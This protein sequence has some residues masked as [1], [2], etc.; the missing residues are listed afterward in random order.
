MYNIVVPPLNITGH[1]HIG[2][3]LNLVLQGIYLHFFRLQNSWANCQ[4]GL[5]H[6]G[7]ATKY[8]LLKKY[9]RINTQGF[10]NW[11]KRIAKCLFLQIK[12]ILNYKICKRLRFS[13]DSPFNVAVKYA[14]VKLFHMK[15][16]KLKTKM[17]WWDRRLQ[18]TISDIDL[19]EVKKWKM[20]LY[21]KYIIMGICL[22][23][24]KK[25]VLNNYISFTKYETM[26]PSCKVI[27]TINDLS[28]MA[29]KNARLIDASTVINAKLLISS[30]DHNNVLAE[31]YIT[32]SL[33]F[34]IASNKHYVIFKDLYLK[35]KICNYDSFKWVSFY[36]N[37]R[38]NCHVSR[39]ISKQWFV[40]LNWLKTKVRTSMLLGNYKSKI[41]A[42]IKLWC[43]SRFIAWG[44]KIPV[45]RFYEVSIV[46]DSMFKASY[47]YMILTAIT[48]KLDRKLTIEFYQESLVFD[49]WFSSALW[50]LSCL[51]WPHK[52]RQLRLHYKS[53]IIITGHDIVFFWV[54]K[55]ILISAA[56]M[57]WQLPFIKIL[58]HPIICDHSGKKMSK[59]KGN[60]ISP[61]ALINTFGINAL[62]L[63]LAG[64]NFNNNNLKIC[65]N[66]INFCK[67]IISKLWNL[68]QITFVN[69]FCSNS[70][71]C[72]WAISHIY[73][74]VKKIKFL[75]NISKL[76]KYQNELL[77]L[78]K[79]DINNI[80][81]NHKCPNH[82]LTLNSIFSIFPIS[83]D[84]IYQFNIFTYTKINFLT[85]S[86]IIQMLYKYNDISTIDIAITNSKRLFEQVSA[87]VREVSIINVIFKSKL[88]ITCNMNLLLWNN[89]LI[90]LHKSQY[91]HY[92]FLKLPSDQQKCTNK[93]LT[94]CHQTPP[95]QHAMPTTSNP[96]G[97]I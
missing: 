35:T 51:G 53:S 71:F 48:L 3:L 36:Y 13:L 64:I 78:V 8:I 43:I 86:S 74:R 58:L 26:T 83:H 18:T 28:L 57:K 44:H 14:F 79:Y 33:L 31:S 47:Y 50:H 40:K 59:T 7:L 66:S 30:K 67:D 38:N 62:N 91:K 34:V 85:I 80:V 90:C 29:V 72:L 87:I 49:T 56:L 55:M 92:Q 2:H 23:W 73:I 70:Q 93:H 76:T 94:I 19:V 54:L 6:A 5:D 69:N 45:W 88:K 24:R 27:T 84:N 10:W 39:C 17:L 61:S 82:K 21:W 52:T 12:Q 11:E 97:S 63:Y 9:G 1:L 15:I 4:I 95:T 41:N 20:Q 77:K 89:S 37:K 25:W 75:F 96:S 22:K 68:K 46:R 60:V 16:A 32:K 81:T 65:I 42:N